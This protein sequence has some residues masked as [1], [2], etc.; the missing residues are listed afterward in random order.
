MSE[1][2]AAVED[3]GDDRSPEELEETWLP[4]LEEQYRSMTALVMGRM[5]GWRKQWRPATPGEL[6]EMLD[7][8]LHFEQHLSGFTPLAH[9]LLDSGRPRLPGR[10]SEMLKDVHDTKEIV[11]SMYQDTVGAYRR[12]AQVQ[13]GT[14][15]QWA[16]TQQ[17]VLQDR[18]Q[19]FDQQFRQ[20]H[21]NY[22]SG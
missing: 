15:R 20:W 2:E 22:I 12:M 16:D 7:M 8:L 13:A 6:T 17:Q 18:R 19:A 11:I 21:Q 10:L 5:E 4:V 3:R 14:A 1:Q 9:H